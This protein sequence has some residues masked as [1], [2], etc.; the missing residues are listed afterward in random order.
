[1]L[2]LAGRPNFAV[3]SGRFNPIQCPFNIII[4]VLGNFDFTATCDSYHTA[5]SVLPLSLTKW[6]L[7]FRLIRFRL[8]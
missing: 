2:P 7:P 1:M 8:F 6:A 4:S 5:I 3:T